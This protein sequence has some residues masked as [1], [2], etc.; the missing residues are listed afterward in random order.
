[1]T[2][3]RPVQGAP[4]HLHLPREAVA[5]LQADEQEQDDG[6]SSAGTQFWRRETERQRD[7]ERVT[8]SE[9]DAT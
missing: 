1:M 9:Y 6:R 8:R 3:P 7:R 2:A 4:L 5:S